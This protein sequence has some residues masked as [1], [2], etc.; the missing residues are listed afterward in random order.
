MREGG[1]TR[2]ADKLHLRPS[3]RRF[4]DIVGGPPTD[5]LHVSLHVT[6]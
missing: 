3:L 6:T 2:G 5:N 4:D 1:S